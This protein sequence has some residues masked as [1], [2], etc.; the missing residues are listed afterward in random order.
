MFGFLP[1]HM[2]PT[3]QHKS[4]LKALQ[5][6]ETQ[7]GPLLHDINVLL[8]MLQ[9]APLDLTA[10][11]RL[12]R[13][14]LEAINERLHHPIQVALKRPQQKSYP[15]IL[16]LYLLLRASGLTQVDETGI[17]PRMLINEAIYEQWQNLKLVERFG[18][19]LETWLLRA[20]SDVVG[21]GRSSGVFSFPRNVE[22]MVRFYKDIPAEG[23]QVAGNRN[24]EELLYIAPEWHNLGLMLEFGMVRVEDSEPEAGKGWNIQRIYR[25]D[26]GDAILP[27]L[28]SDFFSDLDYLFELEDKGATI[29]AL[30]PTLQP[31]FPE[32]QQTL[33]IKQDEF[34]EGTFTF[35]VSLGKVWRRIEI[36]AQHSLDALASTILNAFAFDNDHL[37]LFTYRNQFGAAEEV[38]HPYMD[39][40]PFT[41]EV[42]VGEVPLSE[43]Q[44]MTFL[45]DFGDNWEF[46]VQLEQIDPTRIEKVLRVIEEH[47]EPPEQYPN[48]DW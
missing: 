18:H 24:V 16:G 7:P 25:T 31:Y 43:G 4:F 14:Q 8:E 45:F 34:Q 20:H 36:G 12:S 32:W 41:S 44:S 46:K 47:G 6:T 37:Y 1:E 5:V 21:A 33:T 48:I 35:K 15:A 29:G 10:T 27:V 3:Q 28:V 2:Q 38:F 42:R 17:K 19:L 11:Y 22:K 13:T 23:L 30:Q 39:E 9:V 40:P 26:V